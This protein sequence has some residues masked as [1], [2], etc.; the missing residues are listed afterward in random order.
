MG[1]VQRI[2]LGRKPGQRRIDLPDQVQVSLAELA[3]RTRQGLLAFA[4]DVDLQVFG[5][6]LEEDV[7]AIVGSKGRHNPDRIAY[8][9]TSEPSSVGLGGRRVGVDK[10]RVRS[11]AGEE[12]TLPTWA[13]FQGEEILS[14]MATERMLAGLSSRRYRVG[15]EPV[16]RRGSGTSKSAVSR[17]FVARTEKSLEE[18]L[19]RDLSELKVCAI[20]GDGLE[21]ADH[22]IVAAIGVD[23]EGKKHVLGL[24]EGSTENATVCTGLL[25]DLVDRGLGRLEWRVAGARR[26]QGMEQGRPRR[27]RRPRSG[28]EMQT[29]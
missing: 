11:L 13:A 18:L 12:M 17:R 19:A 23:H 20:F 15:L 26:R 4:V 28:A 6:L 3:G 10:P 16:G 9:H 22:T 21:V 25:T 7:T 8:R 14:E 1:K 27:L 2:A 29:A 24:K 5:T